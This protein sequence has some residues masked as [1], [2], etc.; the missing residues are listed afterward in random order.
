MKLFEIFNQIDP[1]ET[2]DVITKSFKD[3]VISDTLA[4]KSLEGSTSATQIINKLK[5]Q[6]PSI[7]KQAQFTVNPNIDRIR[8]TF[9]KDGSGSNIQVPEVLHPELGEILLLHELA[10]LLYT[11]DLLTNMILK[12]R[13]APQ[14]FT[15]LRVIEDVSIERKLEANF[16]KSAAVFKKRAPHAI[17]AYSSYTPSKFASK[18]D[19]LFLFLRG[20]TNRP[21]SGSTKALSAAERY[22]SSN[23]PQEKIHAVLTITQE[24]MANS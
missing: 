17:S 14:A 10:H 19:Q 7:I 3:T 4:K 20:Y 11:K 5:K 9:N 6:F 2:E 24:L 22:L 16:P 13:D 8:I 18:M 15:V 21:Y 1:Q 12:Y 23:D